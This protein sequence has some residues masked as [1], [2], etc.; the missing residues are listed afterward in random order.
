M[1]LRPSDALKKLLQPLDAR[2][3]AID[4]VLGFGDAG[5]HGL[6]RVRRVDVEIAVRTDDATREVRLRSSAAIRA[7]LPV[8]GV[9]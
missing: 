2:P 1:L 7:R 4:L 3:V 5:T 8:R 6:A 9:P